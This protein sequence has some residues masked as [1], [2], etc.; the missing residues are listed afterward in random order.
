MSIS[1][2]REK[3]KAWQT[4]ASDNI[5][6]KD[7]EIENLATNFIQPA[8]QPG[9]VV[10]GQLDVTDGINADIISDTIEATDLKTNTITDN[11]SSVV[12]INSNTIFNG[13]TVFNDNLVAQDIRVTKVTGDSKII[14]EGNEDSFVWIRSDKDNVVEQDN[15]FLIL[16]QDS[17]GTATYV[18]MSDINELLLRTGTSLTQFGGVFKFISSQFSADGINRPTIINDVLIATF[19]TA[20]CDYSVPVRTGVLRVSSI[21]DYSN[22]NKINLGADT[23]ILS[24]NNV[25]LTAPITQ[26]NS[27][28][29]F[30]SG[31]YEP[32]SIVDPGTVGLSSINCRLYCNNA[33]LRL[34]TLNNNAFGLNNVDLSNPYAQN[35]T[36]LGSPQFA[37]VSLTNYDPRYLTRTLT[38]VPVL[39]GIE[40]TLINW[41]SS[42]GTLGG[43]TNT[44]GVWVVPSNGIYTFGLF[45]GVTTTEATAFITTRIF[46][47][48][49]GATRY[50][51]NLGTSDLQGVPNAGGAVTFNSTNYFA[52]GEQLNMSVRVDS[53]ETIDATLRII[54]I[55]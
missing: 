45:I 33:T 26:L 20:L 48:V 11:G 19:N 21:N 37:D 24:A 18:S 30:A 32:A 17:D 36:T 6:C 38:A 31:S 29:I 8:G 10:F 42:S 4:V 7:G 53:N 55:A 15:A 28:R 3:N 47:T 9:V 27:D 16:S 23:S 25:I 43:F 52:A 34:R 14:V 54:K 50:I 41:V 12:S 46:N 39:N 5:L 2:L 13:E 40:L 44:T 51:S 49:G 22:S 35:L 1:N